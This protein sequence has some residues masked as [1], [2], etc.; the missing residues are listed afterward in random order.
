[1]WHA[2]VLSLMHLLHEMLAMQIRAVLTTLLCCG[3]LLR[4]D[5]NHLLIQLGQPELESDC[6]VPLQQ[7]SM[8]LD[9]IVNLNHAAYSEQHMG[10]NTRTRSAA[11]GDGAIHTD[12][13]VS[14]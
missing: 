13:V 7:C 1:M 9:C 14:H 10:C 3:Q 6:S 2:L 12:A 5:K 11:L 8:L 4:S